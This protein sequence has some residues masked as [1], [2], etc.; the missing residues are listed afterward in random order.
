MTST[1]IEFEVP[2]ESGK[3]E[4]VGGCYEWQVC[5]GAAGELGGRLRGEVRKIWNGLHTAK[6]A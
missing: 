6:R 4:A 5:E 3:E 2:E 1:G